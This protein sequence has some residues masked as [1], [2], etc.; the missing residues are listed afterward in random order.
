MK[1]FSSI[2]DLESLEGCE[3]GVS[4]E[5]VLDQS[6]IDGFAE[7]TG[8]G[9]WT[10]VDAERCAHETSHGQT[11][12]HPALLLGLI[13]QLVG[14]IVAFTANMPT[15]FSYGFNEIRFPAP[16]RAGQRVRLRLGLARIERFR[17]GLQSYWSVL[18]ESPDAEEL[19]LSGEWITRTYLHI[20]FLR[21]VKL[22]LRWLGAFSAGGP[23]EL[24]TQPK[25][26]ET[27]APS[28][29][30]KRKMRSFQDVADFLGKQIGVSDWIVID[31]EKIDA[32]A[33]VTG[34]YYWT[35]SDPVRCKRESP[36]GRTI[37]HGALMLGLIP[38]LVRQIVD[39]NESI[40]MVTCAFDKIRYPAPA[41][42]G[43][44]FQVLL[45]LSRIEQLESD[46]RICW[47]VLF[48]AEDAEKPCLAAEWITQACFPAGRRVHS[49]S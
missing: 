47:T 9:H 23:R 17:G 42:S 26:K 35:H 27:A 48:Q 46:A 33:K 34:D 43:S 22:I 5:I 37:A 32:F 38:M 44:R 1:T 49:A 15:T 41:L 6:M 10:Y 12:A 45:G 4:D 14:K 8:D 16:A 40:T 36:Y 2:R 25:A 18:M 30:P 31:Q 28:R 21:R 7:V 20:G 19:F 13:T 11:V 3:I 39:W 29:R 24:S